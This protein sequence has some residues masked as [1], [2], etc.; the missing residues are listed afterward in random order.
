MSLKND[1]FFVQNDLTLKG[2]WVFSF[3]KAGSMYVTVKRAF[4]FE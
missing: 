3:W 4:A 1:F 2:T